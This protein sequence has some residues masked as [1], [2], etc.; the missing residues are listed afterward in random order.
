MSSPIYN[1]SRDMK[2]IKILA[3][4]LLISTAWAALSR[5]TEKLWPR[6]LSFT[7]DTEGAS[8]SISPCNMKF[9]INAAESAYIQQ[10]ISEYQTKV[11]QCPQIQ[12]TRGEL[13]I[14]VVNGGVLTATDVKQ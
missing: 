4:C 6:P 10:I 2:S 7:Y 14:A 1:L 11:F 13:L 9:T 5:T 8:I 3:L 12:Q